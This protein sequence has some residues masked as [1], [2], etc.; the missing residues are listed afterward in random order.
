[1]PANSDPSASAFE[2]VS[3]MISG[4]S[5]RSPSSEDH[6]RLAKPSCTTTEP[7]VGI[8]MRSSRAY[9]S[10]DASSGGAFMGGRPVGLVLIFGAAAILASSRF[11][12]VFRQFAAN[13]RNHH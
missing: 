9:G 2:I 12:R 8:S 4:A 6:T 1:M 10:N 7:T 3:L 13:A 5:A 11:D